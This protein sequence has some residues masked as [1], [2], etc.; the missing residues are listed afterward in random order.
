MAWFVAGVVLFLG[1]IY[2]LLVAASNADDAMEIQAEKLIVP[3][4][5]PVPAPEEEAE[6][7]IVTYPVPL[8]QE[9]QD[10]IVETCREY[11]VS[12]CYVFAI[13]GVETQGTYDPKTKG[14]Y[15]DGKYHS[16]GLMQ[17]YAS[18]H[19]KRCLR[20]NAINLLDPYQNVR[21]GI[22][23]FAE[24]MD[25]R[26]GIEWALMAYN[27]GQTRADEYVRLGILTDYARC[28]KCNA[29]LIYEG[30]QVHP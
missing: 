20:L 22:D 7:L 27:A 10:Y 12:P 4:V 21:V 24:L 14:D 5:T 28:V 6:K 1:V 17:I 9:L 15:F 16:F 2:C 29:E 30:R 8:D 19:T 13:I 18:E 25:E 3:E 26:K 11:E 23:F